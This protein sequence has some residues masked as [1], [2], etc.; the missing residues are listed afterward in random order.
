MPVQSAILYPRSGS[1]IET[2]EPLK[3][4]TIK[5]YAWSGGG[6][7]IVRVDVSSD[8]GKSWTDAHVLE[9]SSQ[10]YGRY[11]YLIQL[12]S[13]KKILKLIFEFY[14]ESGPGLNGKQRFLFLRSKTLQGMLS[15]SVKRLIQA[16][17]NSLNLG[18]VSTTYEAF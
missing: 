10:E 9:K 15:W 4:L 17:M 8:G 3:E 11:A 18:K 13:A 7:G 6:R 14:K 16:I 5:G 12:F 2:K 1:V